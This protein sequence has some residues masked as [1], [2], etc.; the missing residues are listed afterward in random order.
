MNK[1]GKKFS[2]FVK[3]DPNS[4]IFE[5]QVDLMV[6]QCLMRAILIFLTFRSF[7]NLRLQKMENGLFVRD[8][9]SEI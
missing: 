1:N 8:F 5:T 9:L 4:I 6:S 2:S 3:N 7:M